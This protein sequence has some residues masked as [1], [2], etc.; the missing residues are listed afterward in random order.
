MSIVRYCSQAER[1][2]KLSEGAAMMSWLDKLGNA[3]DHPMAN[4]DEA[5]KNWD[6]AEKE[7]NKK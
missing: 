4:V 2:R 7:F 3:P 5:K 6:K 1:C